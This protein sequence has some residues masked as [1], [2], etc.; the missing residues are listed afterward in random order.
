MNMQ[1]KTIVVTGGFGALRAVVAEAAVRRGASVAALDY[2]SA[3]PAGLAQRLGPKA[4]IVGGFDLSLPHAAQR[5]MSEVSARFG[6]GSRWRT[7]ML[8]MTW[9]DRLEA[10][11]LGM[12]DGV[13]ARFKADPRNGRRKAAGHQ[14]AL[15]S[16]Q[17]GANRLSARSPN[18]SAMLAFEGVELLVVGFDGVVDHRMRSLPNWR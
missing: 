14:P 8:R 2:A 1:G 11:S 5:A 15:C 12:A 18:I 13:I 6:A 4:L 10:G 9:R 16:S 7:R 3:A 17:S